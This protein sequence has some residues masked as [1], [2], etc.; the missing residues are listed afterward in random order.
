MK[1]VEWD[2][3]YRVGVAV[4]DSAHQKLFVIVRRLVLLSENEQRSRWACEESVKYLKSYTL[5]HF[6][7]TRRYARSAAS[8]L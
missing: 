2:E 5:R 6:A 8:D 7:D 1:E 4:I 3:R